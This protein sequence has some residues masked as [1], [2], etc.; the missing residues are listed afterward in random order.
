M[1]D[2]SGRVAAPSVEPATGPASGNRPDPGG[3]DR[4][5]AT[6][7]QDGVDFVVYSK[8]ATG[9]ELLLFD[10]VDAA[11]ATVVK[12]DPATDRTGGYWHVNVPGIGPGQIYGYAADG[13]WDPSS[14]RRFDRSRVLLDPYGRAVATP[15]D[16]RRIPAGDEAPQAPAL[17]SVVVDVGAYDWGDDRPLGRPFRETVIYEAHL[18]GFT[19]HP[20][21]GVAPELRGTYTGF[22]DK[23]PYLVELGITAVEFLPIYQFDRLAAPTGRVN[24]WGY[25]P[26]SFFAPHQQYASR[27]GP[28]SAV[29]EFRD[30]VKALHRAGIE[31]ILDVVYNHTAEDGPD[32][33]TFSF[34][35]LADDDYYLH[36]ADG[37]YL[38]YSGTGN[39]FSANGPIGRRMIMDSLRYWVREMHVD[40]F[41]FDLAAIL[42]RGES[43]EPMRDPPVIWEIETDPVLAGTK[44][45]AEAW[46]AA[47]LYQVGSFAGDRWVEWNG[48]FR[49]DVRSFLKSEPGYARALTQRF[50]GSPDIY[51]HKLRE[52][53]VSVNFVTCHDGFTLDDLVSY[54]QKHN[55]ANGEDNQDGTDDDRSWNSGAE[56]PTDDAVILA[57]RAR[58][59]RNFL[60]VNLL[61]V[62]APMLLMG[63]EVR[64]TQHGNNN[65]YALDDETTW[66]DWSLIDRHADVLRFTRGLIR[67]RSRVA[68]ILDVD[69]ETSLEDLLADADLEWSGIE[70]DE[71]D[72]ADTSHSVALTVRAGWGVLHLIFNAYWEALDFELPPLNNPETGWRRIVDTSLPSPDDMA[73]SLSQ[74]APVTIGRYHV[75]P[76]S[77]V[78]LA[79][80]RSLADSGSGGS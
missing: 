20:N 34:R 72:L 79:A 47:G 76:R 22:V 2:G 26:I 46:D 6:L 35:G 27:P 58:Q 61:A 11:P 25:Q 14:G 38:D 56:G 9:M 3:H 59:V 17:K 73:E 77:V 52:P 70:V 71:P 10:A 62:G 50:L 55:E 48:R 28:A 18:A 74:A 37:G 80:R 66:F 16:Y 45:I 1:T 65:A 64:R 5:G 44:L 32:G 69:P 39:T 42:S 36:D 43:G 7:L 57:R 78:I 4:L 15:G 29:D 21:A 49:D 33:P 31:V 13:P 63:D 60:T 23:I 75:G 30:L 68:A 24:Y 8:H 40:G 41:R 12:L 51:G 53:Q 54:D 19:A 67:L